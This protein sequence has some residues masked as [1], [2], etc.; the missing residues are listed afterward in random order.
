[1]PADYDMVVL[2]G[3]VAGRQAALHA[4]HWQARVALIEPPD[5]QTHI[6]TEWRHQALIQASRDRQRCRETVPFP[7]SGEE[8]VPAQQAW[9]DFGSNAATQ[10]AETLSLAGLAAIGVDVVTAPVTAVD[11]SRPLQLTVGDRRLTTRSLLLATGGTARRPAIAGLEPV[12]VQD[13]NAAVELAMT[14]TPPQRVLLL[15]GDPQGLE[16]AVALQQRGHQVTVVTGRDRL[17]P[18][19]DP[20]L[21]EMIHAQL[22]AQGIQVWLQT[23]P[24]AISP[25]P[26]TSTASPIQVTLQHRGS[27]SAPDRPPATH[28]VDRII[29]AAGQ[30]PDLPAALLP[31]L[32]WQPGE[33]LRVKGTLRTVH[34][35]IYACG[36]GISGA[37]APA[38]TQAEIEVAVGNALFWPTRQIRYTA[39]PW[40]VELLPGFAQVGLT[41][42]QVRD[43]TAATP[44]LIT[45]AS[46][47]PSVA[48]I[49]NLPS[50]QGYLVTD[51]TGQ[52]WGAQF[53]GESACDLVAVIA[54]AMQTRQSLHTLARTQVI[55]TTAAGQLRTLAQQWQQ[56][57]QA[58]PSWRRAWRETWFSWRRSP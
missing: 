16:L 26:P 10:A 12:T 53:L 46:L 1:M 2:G 4:A 45:P 15:G 37:I 33:P 52:I 43:R 9:V 44:W 58:Q 23:T 7:A 48:H 17:L 49:C 36:A 38:A 24:V 55:P 20:D 6:Q 41:V 54:Q 35:Q 56:Y 13:L 28:D 42:A 8:P 31:L 57:R 51:R 40:S 32:Q 22:E 27:A 18:T 21:A 50:V 29:L 14:A 39:L 11:G 5:R 19:T 34:P 25:P 47:A 30:I 3:T